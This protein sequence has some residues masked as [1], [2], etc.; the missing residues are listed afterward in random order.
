MGQ[1]RNGCLAIGIKASVIDRPKLGEDPATVVGDQLCPAEQHAPLGIQP[2]S[3]S[4]DTIPTSISPGS[5]DRR[6]IKGLNF[7]IF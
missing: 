6:K 5:S 3:R 7:D 2:A 1:S 4:S